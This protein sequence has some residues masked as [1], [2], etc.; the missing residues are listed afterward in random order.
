M[1]NSGMTY[2]LGQRSSFH[3][4]AKKK[5]RSVKLEAIGGFLARRVFSF[6]L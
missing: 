3:F 4:F 2:G 6:T 1:N 5:K